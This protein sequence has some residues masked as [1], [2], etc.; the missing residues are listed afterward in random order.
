MGFHGISWD[1]MEWSYDADRRLSCPLPCWK[2]GKYRASAEGGKISLPQNFRK[3]SGDFFG[4]HFFFGANISQLVKDSKDG[5]PLAI[6]SCLHDSQWH[7]AIK[8]T[9]KNYL[10]HPLSR[11][12]MLVREWV[13]L[14]QYCGK[15][16]KPSPSHHRCY[17]CINDPQYVP[18]A[19]PMAVV[20]D[21]SG[22][23][24]DWHVFC[25]PDGPA[26]A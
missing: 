2:D 10:Y 12:I 3:P 20:P 18:P 19:N 16:H 24:P 21:Y 5:K 13:S 22:S 7:I 25:R 8:F 11:H 1:F 17:G 9:Q 23:I 6:V 26:A 15:H 4:P 14:L